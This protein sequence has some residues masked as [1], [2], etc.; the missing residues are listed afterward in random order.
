ME[1]QK[2]WHGIAQRSYRLQIEE[3]AASD[4]FDAG[5]RRSVGGRWKFDPRESFHQYEAVT[6]DA[7]EHIPQC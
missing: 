6:P 7:Q 3:L 4:G 5:P 1:R 2:K